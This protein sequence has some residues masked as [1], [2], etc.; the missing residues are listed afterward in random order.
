MISGLVH[1]EKALCHGFAVQNKTWRVFLLSHTLIYLSQLHFPTALRDISAVRLCCLTKTKNI[2]LSIFYSCLHYIEGYL[3][4][5]LG[6]LQTLTEGVNV[7]R[8]NNFE[9]TSMLWGQKKN[10]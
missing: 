2:T 3:N 6:E 4:S 10:L 5:V 7:L 9:I 8:Q 1:Q